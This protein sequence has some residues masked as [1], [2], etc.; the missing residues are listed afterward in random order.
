MG[1][2]Y[3]ERRTKLIALG[4]S[5][6]PLFTNCSSNLHSEAARRVK[7]MDVVYE[8]GDREGVPVTK[9]A[10]LLKTIARIAISRLFFAM[11]LLAK[12]E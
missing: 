6:S 7:H 12:R 1:G 9:L 3:S 8:R 4:V 5:P 11:N 2:D 10:T